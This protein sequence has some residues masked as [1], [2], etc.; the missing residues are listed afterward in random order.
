MVIYQSR[1]VEVLPNVIVT[2]RNKTPT[3]GDFIILCNILYKIVVIPQK[4]FKYQS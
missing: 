3:F 1:R 2:L 4:P